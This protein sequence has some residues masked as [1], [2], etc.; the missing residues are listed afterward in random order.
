[1]SL[2]EVDGVV[3]R[4]RD[5][6]ALSEVSVRVEEGEVLAIVGANGAG[7]STLLGSIAGM[8]EVSAGTLTF[9]GRSLRGLAPHRRVDLGIAMVPEGRR[10]FPSLSVRENLQVGAHRRRPGPWHLDRVLD[11]LPLLARLTDRPAGTLSGGE[12]QAVA[13]GRA[14]MAN[15]RLLLLD[16][17][18]LGL[19]PIV[20]RQLY[21]SLPSIVGAGITV[22]LVEQDL[23]QAMTSADR[24]YCLQE[25]RISLHGRPPDLDRAQITTA[26]FGAGR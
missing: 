15:P 13:I 1:M 22:L 16:E 9:D 11:L 14:L 10:L 4:Y 20:V 7:K 26:Y 12:Q 24:L 8:V 3:A 19:A 25:G 5:F 2:L 17:L 6:Q 18:S 21:Q 23:T